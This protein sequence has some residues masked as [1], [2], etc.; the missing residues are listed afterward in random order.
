MDLNLKWDKLPAQAECYDDDKTTTLLFSGGLGSGKTYSLCRKAIKLSILNRGFP[1]GLLVPAYSDFRRDVM[2]TF[3]EIFDEAK[4]IEGK[5]WWFNKQFKEYRFA[6]NRKPLYIFTAENPIAG[7][8]LAYCLINEHS[9]IRFERIKEMLRRVRVKNAPFKQ[10]YMAG[11]PEDVHGWLEDFVEAQQKLEEGEFKIVYSD[12]RDNHHIDPDYRKHLE[13]MLDEQ[14]L[15]VFAGGQIVRLGGDYYYYSFTRAKNVRPVSYNPEELIHCGLDFNVG[16]MACSFSHKRWCLE[17]NRYE[18]HFFDELILKGDSN[19]PRMAEAIANRYPK[20]NMLITCDAAGKNRSSVGGSDV[21]VLKQHGYDVR[22]KPA[23]P[24]HRK[25]QLLINGLMHHG[26]V[27]VDPSCK[28]LIKDFEKVQQNKVDFAK[29]KDKDDNLTHFSDGA[30]YVLDWEFQ[31]D[32]TRK[33][34]TYLL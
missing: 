18:Q 2:P 16:K 4:L 13:S 5:H 7:P 26:R 11:T 15:K 6:W 9:L 19:T 27:I 25:R 28:L 12:T 31:L 20:D 14:S 24:R 29:A 3:E 23:N 1:G 17:N 30:D 22:Y 10:R 34:K 33:T 21:Q 8:N 32:N